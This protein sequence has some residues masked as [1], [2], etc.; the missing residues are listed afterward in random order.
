MGTLSLNGKAAKRRQEQQEQQEK[1][2]LDP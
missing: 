2:F 1:S